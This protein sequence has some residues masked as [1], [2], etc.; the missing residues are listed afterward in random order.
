[1]P[2]S[3]I[4]FPTSTTMIEYEAERFG[5]YRGGAVPSWLRAAA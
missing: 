3:T 5:R 4:R 2:P 1:M